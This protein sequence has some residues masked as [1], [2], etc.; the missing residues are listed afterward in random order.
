M[1]NDFI[2][3]ALNPVADDDNDFI[4]LL[5]AEDE[6]QMRQEKLPELLP[7]LP[8]RN[9][10]LFPGVVIPITVSRERSIQL[11][12]DHNRQEKIIGV[13]TQ[14]N[15]TVEDP[16]AADLH[17][18]GT[19]AT[20]LKTLRL[21]DG[22]TTVIIQGKK[23]FQIDQFI[24]TEPYFKAQISA[25]DETQPDKQDAEFQAI[26][27]N[28]KETSLQ[29]IKLSPHIPSEASF[30]INNIDSPNFLVNFISSNMNIGSA[31]KQ[32]LLEINNLKQ[33]SLQVLEHLN[34]ELQ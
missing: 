1:S 5:S 19:L 21:P 24:Q 20:I 13:T 4:P 17:K 26:I 12:K 23:R 34:K 18:T 32:Q 28:L 10:V 29:I 3:Y 25:L 8:L 11:I 22:N 2:P 15:D 14:K 31:E 6:D 16:Q 27:S 9:A 7:I 33:R 30:A